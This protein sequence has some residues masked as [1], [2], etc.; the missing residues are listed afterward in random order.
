MKN[1][2][3]LLAALAMFAPVTAFADH[4]KDHKVSAAVMAG[5][6]VHV[7]VNGM[8]CDFCAQS[9]KKVFLKQGAV[10]KVDI[11]LEDKLITLEL[12]KGKAIDDATI[13][14]LVVDAGYEVSS[15]H[16]MTNESVK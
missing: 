5:D 13:K 7:G 8:V 4:T 9:L 14:K 12:K 2:I 6:T 15:I 16:H 10:Q 1:T 11:S 3:I